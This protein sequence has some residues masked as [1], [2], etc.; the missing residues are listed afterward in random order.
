MPLRQHSHS[1]ARTHDPL[2]TRPVADFELGDVFAD[3]FDECPRLRA[4]R[5][6][7]CIL[8]PRPGPVVAHEVHVRVAETGHVDFDE[9]FVVGGV[10]DGYVFDLGTACIWAGNCR[11]RRL[12]GCLGGP[13][14]LECFFSVFASVDKESAF[15]VAGS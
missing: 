5:T 9:D 11:R 4:R 10:R 8:M 14:L 2:D 12:F 3:F 7:T 13:L 6:Y 1:P 15:A